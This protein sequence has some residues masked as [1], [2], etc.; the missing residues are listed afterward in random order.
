MEATSV[1]V[2]TPRIS[3]GRNGVPRTFIMNRLASPIGNSK[4]SITS[5]AMPTLPINAVNNNSTA[6]KSSHVN[7]HTFGRIVKNVPFIISSMDAR[8]NGLKIMISIRAVSKTFGSLRTHLTK[9]R[10]DFLVVRLCFLLC[11]SS[12]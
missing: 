9:L 11:L 8:N 7:S 12:F 10:G 6:P 5:M 4:R 3:A 2:A 1:A